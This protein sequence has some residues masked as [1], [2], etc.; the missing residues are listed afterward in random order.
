MGK[1][2]GKTTEPLRKPLLHRNKAAHTGG[3]PLR[4]FARR[5]FRT[6]RYPDSAGAGG[7]GTSAVS[8]SG[9]VS[10][11]SATPTAGPD[12]GPAAAGCRSSGASVDGHVPILS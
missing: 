9:G 4:H 8:A 1:W 12:P 5:G 2:M 3:H 10:A 7:A 11:L 6:F